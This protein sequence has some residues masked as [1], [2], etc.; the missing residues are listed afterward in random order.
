MR[1]KLSDFHLE[2]HAITLGSALAILICGWLVAGWIALGVRRAGER[3]GRVSP[4]LLPLLHKMT[5]LS[6]LAIVVMAALE[7][8]GVQ[9]DG[10]F[11]IVGAA[12]L[13]IGLALKDTV[14][15]I[16]A[17]VV[18]LTLRPFEV[19]DGVDIGGTSGVINE[20]GLFQTTLTSFD[21]V[22]I[23]L[24]NS[25]VRTATI[26][27]FARAQVRRVDLEIGISYS[28]NIST[29]KTA[30]ESV[31]AADQRVLNEP[32]I[33]VDTLRLD[34]SAV[35]LLARYHTKAEDFFT[36]KLELTRAI[37]ERLDREGISIPFPQRDI[38]LIKDGAA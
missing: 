34:D 35:V 38:H 29:A 5:R 10:L 17:G 3:S 28:D 25:S 23:M 20:I 12:G 31:L 14:S 26:Q 36:A 37:K 9:T 11:A 2:A 27:N 15:D 4:T 7:K 24:N 21:G 18:L 13:A 16:A 19:G 33:V 32:A 30:I 1:M 6:L 22:P 8:L